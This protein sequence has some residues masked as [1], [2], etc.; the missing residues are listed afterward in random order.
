M[1]LPLEITRRFSIYKFG[2]R[3]SKP[4]R[5]IKKD[6]EKSGKGQKSTIFV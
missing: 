1:Q 3:F 2:M 5:K 6:P 4:Q